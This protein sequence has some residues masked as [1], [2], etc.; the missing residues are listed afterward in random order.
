MTVRLDDLRDSFEGIIPSIIATVD[1]AGMPNISYLSHVYYVDDRHVALSNQFFSKTAANVR[2]YGVATVMVI[3]GRTGAHHILDLEFV[4]SDDKGELFD[5]VASHLKVMSAMRGMDKV[6]ALR[7]LDIYRVNGIKLAPAPE[8]LEPAPPPLPPCNRLPRAAQ[9]AAVIAAQCDADAM[10]DAAL[11]GLAAFG[12]DHAMI[13]MCDT[14]GGMLSTIASHGYEQEGAGS[15]VAVGEGVIGM[16]AASARPVRISDLGRASRYVTAVLAA[17]NVRHIPVPSLSGS[18]SQMA[19]PMLSQ[20][21]VR[22]V[23][24]VEDEAPFAFRHE[25]EDALVLV[26]GQ[27]ASA[28]HLAELQAQAP[29]PAARFPARAEQQPGRA[30]HFKYYTYDDSVFIDGDYLIKGVPGRLLYHFV[31]EYADHGRTDFSNREIRRDGALKLPDLKDNLETRL[32][33]LRRRLEEK[34]GPVRLIRPERGRI[35]L[36]L[37]GTPRIEVLSQ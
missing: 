4:R 28:L 16:A 6:M 18:Q 20:G 25:D 31:R 13:L 7:G 37:A 17:S 26:A 3:D 22:G 10:V 29:A 8:P 36:E 30:F 5:R 32:I 27:L 11:D 33:L 24:F 34:G 1:E 14:G 9:L 12:F 2:L 35:R 23:I 19:V 21:K 15:Q